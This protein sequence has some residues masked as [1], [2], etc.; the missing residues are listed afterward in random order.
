MKTKFKWVFGGIKR[1][2]SKTGAPKEIR[3]DSESESESLR[4]CPLVSADCC[5]YFLCWTGFCNELILTALGNLTVGGFGFV[6]MQISWWPDSWPSWHSVHGLLVQGTPS[7]MRLN[8]IQK[9][10][11]IGRG[12][13]SSLG[14]VSQCHVNFCNS[15]W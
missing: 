2:D 12:P 15:G 9:R 14:P 3:S 4:A 6:S 8:T 1:T 13:M 5:Y 7:V 11:L 10:F